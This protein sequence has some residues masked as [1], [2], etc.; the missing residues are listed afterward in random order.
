MIAGWADRMEALGTV[1][2]PWAVSLSQF[3][4]LYVSQDDRWV[5]K[6]A[7][8]NENIM[9]QTLVPVG[10]EQVT[11][12][13]LVEAYQTTA[14]NTEVQV[15]T[16]GELP[17]TV[18]T[19]Q[20]EPMQEEEAEQTEA[21]TLMEA[22]A[23]DEEAKQGDSPEIVYLDE[24]GTTEEV[25]AETGFQETRIGH[26]VGLA[27]GVTDW[28]GVGPLRINAVL[29]QP[30]PG[31]EEDNRYYPAEMLKRDA[32]VFEGGKMYPTDHRR[33]EKSAAT[34][35][36]DII[37]CPIGFTVEGGPMAEVGIFDPTFARK[38]YN[39]AKLGT[40][41]NLHVSIIGS[42][43]TRKGKIDEAEY[44]V[45]Q[46]ITAGSADFV[47]QAGA[48]GHAVSI[49]ENDEPQVEEPVVEPET[50][51]EA[52]PETEPENEETMDTEQVQEHLNGLSG[53]PKAVQT[54]LA[55]REYENTVTID[56]AVQ[57]EI[58]YIKEATGSGNPVGQSESAEPQTKGRSPEEHNT[59][60]SELY[61]R[62]GWVY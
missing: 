25:L 14:S 31:N 29:I 61:E 48:G 42:G 52:E 3:K 36:A 10:E 5:R 6:E 22:E 62:N 19:V 35:C 16:G 1:D 24:A 8:V 18:M 58:D 20:D 26:A 32:H 4:K 12:L 56:E 45:V 41:Q 27:E 51:P 34:E 30:G 60:V 15:V 44:S 9:A 53:V 57:T 13:E 49:A 37:K 39:R 33:E 38:V 7:P 55:E 17:S 28:D 59:V 40:I 46:N 23:M 21:A 43:E 47:T 54:R 11:L 2:N 50:E